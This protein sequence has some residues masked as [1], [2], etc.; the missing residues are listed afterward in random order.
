MAERNRQRRAKKA[1]KF[2]KKQKILLNVLTVV[3]FAGL[4][5]S[6]IMIVL[7]SN[8]ETRDRDRIENDLSQFLNPSSEVG[9]EDPYKNVTFPAGILEEMKPFYAR[10]SET[11]GFLYISGLKN[12]GYP[13]V[14]TT[15]NDKYYRKDLDLKS[16]REGTAFVDCHV[17]M[18]NEAHSWLIHGH[19][20]KNGLMFGPLAK[21]NAFNYGISQYKAAPVITFTTL[22]DVRFYKIVSV[23]VANVHWEDGPTFDFV[24]IDL[25]NED[26]FNQF[27]YEIERRSVINTGVDIE[28]GDNIMTLHTCEYFFE[29]SRLVVFAR[30]TRPGE[31]PVVDTSGATI[32]NDAVMPDTYVDIYG[33]GK[34]ASEAVS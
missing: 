19:N 34:K 31:S 22:Y 17:D 9:G 25:S 12:F 3:C 27:K 2:T 21:Y 16:S 4:V 30:E 7:N 26:D 8:S 6:V 32:N 28:Y 23:V 15:N 11:V 18:Q 13:I 20:N 1:V 24:K 5:F 10:N 29:K 14:Q 33:K